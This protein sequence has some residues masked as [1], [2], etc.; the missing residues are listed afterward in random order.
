MKL[1][2]CNQGM[3]STP[4]RNYCWK[5][6]KSNSWAIYLAVTLNIVC[7]NKPTMLSEP[8][9]KKVHHCSINKEDV[10]SH[11]IVQKLKPNNL[12]PP[13]QGPLTFAPH[14]LL[15]KML[16][17]TAARLGTLV[18]AHHHIFDILHFRGS[19]ELVWQIIDQTYKIIINAIHHTNVHTQLLIYLVFILK[20]HPFH[21]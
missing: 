5:Q 10:S 17:T 9:G 3:V 13:Q 18:W 16:S 2:C 7:K 11:K 20:I 8:A 19:D 15:M 6:N 21:E 12:L 14:P 1:H 4:D